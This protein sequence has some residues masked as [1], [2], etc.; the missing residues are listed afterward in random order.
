MVGNS[1][2]KQKRFSMLNLLHQKNLGDSAHQFFLLVDTI[3]SLTQYFLQTM[4]P[5][6]TILSNNEDSLELMYP[7]QDATAVC[8][9]L[10][11]L[12]DVDWL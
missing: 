2:H 5:S 8:V 1:L 3:S 10:M 7:K 12:P 9:S 6:T 4:D 11:L